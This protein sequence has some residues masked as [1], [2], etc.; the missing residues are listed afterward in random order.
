MSVSQAAAPP[1]TLA[2]LVMCDDPRSTTRA[3]LRL[4]FVGREF[5][6]NTVT[7]LWSH[8]H[9]PS[10][11]WSEARSSLGST[12][13]AC[14]RAVLPP[15]S[16]Y[17]WRD[18]AECPAL[19]DAAL[20]GDPARLSSD[21]LRQWDALK[22]RLA[23]AAAAELA[24]RHARFGACGC[25]SGRTWAAPG[26]HRRSLCVDAFSAVAEIAAEDAGAPAG[27]S[28]TFLFNE[29]VATSCVTAL[30][31]RARRG[32]CVGQRVADPCFRSLGRPARRRR[33]RASTCT[34]A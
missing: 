23:A 22:A 18:D 5:A 34:A 7:Y 3:A 14:R 17:G 11:P 6:S 9:A 25:G 20:V 12:P 30:R 24:A 16:K 27:P 31:V 10:D 29:S 21:A 28:Y 13:G 4:S 8:D 15:C 32:G 1:G 33:C 26:C 2:Q 19:L